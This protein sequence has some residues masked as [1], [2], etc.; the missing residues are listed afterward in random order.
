MLLSL[1]GL[2]GLN[3]LKPVLSPNRGHWPCLLSVGVE[4]AIASLVDL[5]GAH[6]KSLQNLEHD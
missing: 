5:S 3:H 4:Q 2:N 6:L 1:N